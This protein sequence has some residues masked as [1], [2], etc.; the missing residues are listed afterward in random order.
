MLNKEKHETPIYAKVN[1]VICDSCTFN[2]FSVC[3]SEGKPEVKYLVVVFF[4]FLPLSPLF[5]GQS[6]KRNAYDIALSP[7]IGLIV[8]VN[9][10][11][12]RNYHK[13]TENNIFTTTLITLDLKL[14]WH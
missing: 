14:H 1:N 8:F 12:S 4:L 3:F 11:K 13:N 7:L 2:T 6:F 5:C 10:I 9:Y